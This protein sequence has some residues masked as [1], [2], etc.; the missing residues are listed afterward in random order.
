MPQHECHQVAYGGGLKA[1]FDKRDRKLQQ[2]YKEQRIA[3]KVVDCQS[4]HR[5]D[6]YEQC[7]GITWTIGG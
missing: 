3:D 7:Y 1:V 2:M 6:Q 4:Y 5:F